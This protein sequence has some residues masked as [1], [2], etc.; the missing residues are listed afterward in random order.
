VAIYRLTFRA[1]PDDIPEAQRLRALLKHARRCLR[2]Q[3]T[4][5]E[6]M[7]T[8]DPESWGGW[9]RLA[10]GW[11]RVCCA[12]S[13]EECRALLAERTDVNILDRKVFPRG[14]GP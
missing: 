3:A 1:L 14:E 6:E 5:V 11:V 2:L 8:L 10:R 12:R 9:L 7:P 4:L 13:E